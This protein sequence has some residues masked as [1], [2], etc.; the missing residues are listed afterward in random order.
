MAEQEAEEQPPPLVVLL[1]DPLAGPRSVTQRMLEADGHKVH[2]GGDWA[3]AER[4]LLHQQ[5]EAVLIGLTGF[6]FDGLKAVKEFRKRLPPQCD[7]PVVG[8]GTGQQRSEDRHAFDAGCDQLLVRPFE[9]EMLRE[10]LARAWRLRRPPQQLDDEKRAALRTVHGPA[11]LAA[12]DDA[13]IAEQAAIVARFYEH[14]ATTEEYVAAGTA[15]AAALDGIGLVAARD[16]AERLV[17]H[18][19]EGRRRVYPLMSALIKARVAL[20]GDRMIA[21]RQDPIWAASDT[22]PGETQ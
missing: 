19:A 4:H 11:A 1:V 20:R 9:P 5:I 3:A 8:I 22:T 15:M 12:L 13:V 10:A 7:L 14:G 18:S 16:T 6:G 17:T 21:A 2:V